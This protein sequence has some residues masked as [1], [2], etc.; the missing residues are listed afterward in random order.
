MGNEAPTRI[1]QNFTSKILMEL[2]TFSAFAGKYCETQLCEP[3]ELKVKL[4]D[5]AQKLKPK[6]FVL[7]RCELMGGSFF[8][9]R[10][11]LPYGGDSTLKD[12][13]TSPISP[14]GL[15]SDMSVVE[16]VMEV[17]SLEEQA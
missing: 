5:L 1:R 14:R 13:P 17:K 8:G 12:V 9:Q 4:R 3:D 11:I 6:G 2:L 7:L 10:V 15:A 16:A